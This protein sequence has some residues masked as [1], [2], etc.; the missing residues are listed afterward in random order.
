M[1]QTTQYLYEYQNGK[2]VRNIGFKKI[3]KQMDKYLI[4]IYAKDVDGV[5]GILFQKENG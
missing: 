2:R 3:E 4:Q 1:E 5:Q